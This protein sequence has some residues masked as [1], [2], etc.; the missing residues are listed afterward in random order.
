MTSHQGQQQ[1]IAAQHSH[2][3]LLPLR[4]SQQYIPAV[5]L[6]QFRLPNCKTGTTPFSPSTSLPCPGPGAR[7]AH[8]KRP[9]T[10]EMP[11][12]PI[13]MA[14]AGFAEMSHE[15][16]TQKWRAHIPRDDGF[17]QK[18]TNKKKEHG[19]FRRRALANCLRLHLAQ[20]QE[21]SRLLPHRA[22]YIRPVFFFAWFCVVFRVL[23]PALFRHS[24]LL[25]PS[26]AD[27]DVRWCV[28]GGGGRRAVGPR[29]GA[30]LRASRSNVGGVLD[31]GSASW[32]A[33]YGRS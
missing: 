18:M 31:R 1:K 30:G 25:R 6:A 22:L 33:H 17:G 16:N 3:L 8:R 24:P 12:V 9:S 32:S 7:W 13:D 28:V 19:R 20:A 23:S 10:L 27:F 5:S 2:H 21:N 15:Y 14:A 26:T 4:A 29:G 11:T